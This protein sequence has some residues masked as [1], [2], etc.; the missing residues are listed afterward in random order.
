MTTSDKQIGLLLAAAAVA[1]LALV[2]VRCGGNQA[3]VSWPA[4]VSCGE[5]VAHSDLFGRVQ[6]I[7][8]APAPEGADPNTISDRARG[9]LEHLAAEH[10]PAVIACL[11]A[12]AAQS[13]ARV[14]NQPQAR[15]MSAGPAP[16]GGL[17][18]AD[19]QRTAEVAAT[20]GRDFLQRVG[21][22]VEGDGQ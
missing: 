10:G 18:V 13:F 20:R 17:P 19:E 11:V 9:E 14:A 12:Q 6:R 2:I 5:G 8:L 4:V 15:A 7:L 3:A 22:T 16:D 21:T 1:V